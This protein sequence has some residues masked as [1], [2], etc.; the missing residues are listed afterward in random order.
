MPNVN[1]DFP[2]DGAHLRLHGHDAKVLAESADAEVVA[3]DVEKD[4]HPNRHL[5]L[6]SFFFSMYGQELNKE[7]KLSL[8]KHV[9]AVALR[10]NPGRHFRYFEH[11]EAGKKNLKFPVVFYSHDD[12]DLLVRACDEWKSGERS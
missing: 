2:E 9:K 12:R 3:S 1:F 11:H 10:E 7:E 5:R 6:P 4:L 8:G